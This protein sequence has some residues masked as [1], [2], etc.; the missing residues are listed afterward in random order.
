MKAST[1]FSRC[2]RWTPWALLTGLAIYG[3]T[4]LAF[5]VG[6]AFDRKQAE[7]KHPS[8]YSPK[9]D[10]SPTLHPS[11]QPTLTNEINETH[12]FPDYIKKFTDGGIF[13][14]HYLELL[15]IAPVNKVQSKVFN[16]DLFDNLN[17]IGIANFE[18]KTIAPFEDKNAGTTIANQVSKELQSTNKFNIIPPPREKEDARLEIVSRADG[19]KPED[20]EV[21]EKK[22]E[23]TIAGLPFT[24]KNIDAVI[25][26]AVTRYMDSYIDRQGKLK[27]SISSGV[28]FGAYLISTKTG[29]V[30]WG[31]RY[32]GS[33][34]PS[35]MN[36]TRG[37]GTWLSKQKLSR[38]I[39]KTVLKDFYKAKKIQ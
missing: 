9:N 32:V 14:R 31:A 36:I 30:I 25:I 1:Q 34:S 8:G 20:I 6:D 4:A 37:Q 19:G 2:Y 28:E 17:R 29:E 16:Q 7:P 5:P 23:Q 33:Q 18:N 13:P 35:L 39:M 26:G 10:M 11:L 12:P 3:S 38:S 22:K 27:K 24:Y 21:F 15:K